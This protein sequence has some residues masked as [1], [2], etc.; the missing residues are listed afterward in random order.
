MTTQAADPPLPVI[1]PTLR[2]LNSLS[3]DDLEHA[4]SSDILHP[5]QLSEGPMAV[6]FA[7]IV[8]L[9][10]RSERFY[11]ET[12][13]YSPW[14][15]WTQEN[16]AKRELAVIE[17]NIQSLWD[18]FLS[19]YRSPKDIES[20]L[21]TPFFCEEDHNQRVRGRVKLCLSVPRIS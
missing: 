3:N 12:P 8:L 20:A 1:F 5:S 15:R 7:L 11:D 9:A 21:W 2:Q 19:S 13:P 16:E 14:D 17:N 4:Y 10:H 18:E 6:A